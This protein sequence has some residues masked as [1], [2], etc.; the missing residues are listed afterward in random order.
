MYNWYE[1][2]VVCYAYLGDVDKDVEDEIRKSRWFTRGWTLQELVAPKEVIFF[3][4]NW[5]YLGDKKTL[6]TLL[7]QI[8]TIP[9]GVLAKPFLTQ[10]L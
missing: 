5:N 4:K 2:S 9:E 10:I 8:T 1:Q 6:S 7:S 3:D